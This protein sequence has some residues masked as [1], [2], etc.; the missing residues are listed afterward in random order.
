MEREYEFT[1]RV[2]VEADPGAPEDAETMRQVADRIVRR[3]GPAETVGAG[4]CALRSTRIAVG[5]VNEIVAN[6]C[7][8]DPQRRLGVNALAHQ[9]GCVL[10]QRTGLTATRPVKRATTIK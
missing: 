9:P 6:R 1:V 5:P 4:Q 3:L 10:R 8:C 2:L 7:S